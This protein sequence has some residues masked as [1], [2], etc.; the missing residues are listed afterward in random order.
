[1]MK[2]L[3]VVIGLAVIIVVVVANQTDVKK[4][5]SSSVTQPAIRTDN[6]PY[7][8][9]EPAE[10]SVGLLQPQKHMFM[11]NC[12]PNVLYSINGLGP[13]YGWKMPKNCP[14]TQFVQPP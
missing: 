12:N 11:N 3:F 13:D 6:I 10:F 5:G 4:G 1:M 7:N 9:I 8:Y 14:C 2:E